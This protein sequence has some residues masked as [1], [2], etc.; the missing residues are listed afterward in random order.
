MHQELYIKAYSVINEWLAGIFFFSYNNIQETKLILQILSLDLSYENTV[1]LLFIFIG[2]RYP[3]QLLQ[4]FP[5]V[6][7]QNTMQLMHQ[8]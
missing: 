3:R 2:T 4:L 1:Q 5:R 7:R 8:I 6:H